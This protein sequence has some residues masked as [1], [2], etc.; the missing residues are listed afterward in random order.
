[1]KTL[2]FFKSILIPL[3]ISGDSLLLRLLQGMIG[4]L[5]AG[6]G[7]NDNLVLANG[8]ERSFLLIL[9]FRALAMKQGRL[10]AFSI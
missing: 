6:A 1:M 5:H 9:F 3:H 2:P 8:M 7:K 4:S 10:S